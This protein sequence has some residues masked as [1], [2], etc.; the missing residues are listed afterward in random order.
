MQLSNI[1]SGSRSYCICWKSRLNYLDG[2][3]KRVMIQIVK[4][5][6]NWILPI[7]SSLL[8]LLFT[9]FTLSYCFDIANSAIRIGSKI[10]S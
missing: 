5:A 1:V 6:D 7:F 10:I 3:I 8:F 4:K 2:V 9:F